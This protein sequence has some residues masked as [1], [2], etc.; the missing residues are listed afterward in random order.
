M[1]KIIGMILL[2]QSILI[3]IVGLHVY[4]NI[5]YT[6]LLYEDNTA[7]L[8]RAEEEDKL[9]SFLN[10]KSEKDNITISKYAYIDDDNLVIYTNDISLGGK[11]SIKEYLKGDTES[12]VANYKSTKENQ[13]AKFYLFGSNQKITIFP[14]EKIKN[15]GVDGLY[16]IRNEFAEQV[17]NEINSDIGYAEVYYDYSVNIA[18][19]IENCFE[20]I[21]AIVMVTI[22]LVV[23][24]I[25]YIV[26]RT[27]KIAILKIQGLSVGG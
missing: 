24:I 14:L 26:S 1:K 9:T 3:C 25:H 10:E 27:K 5:S 16:Y 4:K 11:I 7:I 2:A 15:D 18:S 20:M 22:I 8:V 13:I 21:I 19:Y 23:S 6:N 17:V 12:I